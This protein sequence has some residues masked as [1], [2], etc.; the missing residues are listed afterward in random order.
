MKKSS[1][2]FITPVLTLLA[3]LMIFSCEESY[4]NNTDADD[5]A[6]PL[7][8]A[9]T[10][11]KA[12]G[13]GQYKSRVLSGEVVSIKLDLSELQPVSSLT[14]RKTVNGNVDATF[15]TN[16]VITVNAGSL[17]DMY[18]FDYTTELGDIDQLV[19]LTFEATGG[20]GAVIASDLTL[21]VTLSPRD[22][23]PQKRWAWTSKIWV[24]AGNV[25]DL[26]ECEK[27]NYWL[28]NAD[29]TMDVNYGTDTGGGDCLFDGFNVYHS[30]ELS[31][32]GKFF[33]TTRSGLFDPTIVTEVYRV[34]SLTTEKM[35]LEI[36]LD[37]TIFGLTAE[38]TFVYEYTA[39]PK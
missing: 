1:K 35:L 27:D 8:V 19:G 12:P 33:T 28:F 15:G 3:A 38:E 26:K 17:S 16:G 32:D 20:D 25:E 22:N 31:E 10:S 4:D 5:F 9:D 37:L 30:W 6:I 13:R 29:G 18:E 36:D 7:F 23:I 24:D 21:V 34:R 39:M 14:I 11:V 2:H